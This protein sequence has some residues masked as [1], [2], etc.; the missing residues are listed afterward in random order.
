MNFIGQQVRKLRLCHPERSE[1]SS[2]T[3]WIL[4]FVQNDSQTFYIHERNLV[5]VLIDNI[6]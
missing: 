1:G 4:H 6:K 5:L 2:L 3:F